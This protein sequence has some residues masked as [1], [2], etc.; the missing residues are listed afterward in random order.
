MPPITEHQS[1]RTT[2][3]LLLGH[4]GAGKTGA[5]ASLAQAGY[6][7]RI[8]DLDNG[9]DILK[10]YLS[11]PKSQYMR[12]GADYS[13]SVTFQ[14]LTDEMK[15]SGGTVYP[16]RATV[17]QR[18]MTQL[19][20]WTDGTEKLG[21]LATWTEKDI[22]VVD[23][24]S[25]LAQAALNFDHQMNGFLGKSPTQN[26][27][28]RSVWRAQ[29][30]LRGFL[31]LIYDENIKANVI[32]T[33]HITFASDMGS[34]QKDAQGNTDWTSVQGFPNAVGKALSPHIPRWFNSVLVARTVGAGQHAKHRIYTSSQMIDGVVI[35]GKTSAPSKVLAEYPLES[36]LADYF[37]ALR[38]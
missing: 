24:L 3:L 11:S 7:L 1:S 16:V 34:P 25:T 18:V 23:S 8:L 5:L 26:E 38:S 30:L 6:N 35:T 37:K 9:L 33:A 19:D 10:D 12:N 14:T 22:L 15:Q 32:L 28:R 4:S 17:W 29:D 27:A 20:G 36:G 13:K 2:K 31:N 21:K